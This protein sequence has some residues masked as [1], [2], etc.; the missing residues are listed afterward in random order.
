[1]VEGLVFDTE[2][3]EEDSY[4]SDQGNKATFRL[5]R[6]TRGEKATR[7]AERSGLVTEAFLTIFN[8]HNG[9]YGHG[10]TFN[11]NGK[12]VQKDDVWVVTDE[13]LVIQDGGL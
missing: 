10:F 4:G 6:P 13:G 5:Y 9:Y 12:L 8:D 2:Y 3:F 1:L 11:M 7:A